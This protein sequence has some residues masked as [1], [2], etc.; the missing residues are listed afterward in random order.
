MQST[1]A[2]RFGNVMTIVGEVYDRPFTS[3]RLQAWF[4][5]LSDYAIED[6]ERSAEQHM[7]ASKFMP[8]PAELIGLIQPS[9]ADAAT[10]A[11]TEVPAL[12]RDSRNAKSANPVTE[13]TIQALGG[14]AALGQKTQGELVWIAKEFV[15]RYQIYV[16]HGLEVTALP[17]PHP[18]L[19]ETKQIGRVR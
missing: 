17:A 2:E 7:R 16:K 1:D 12:L 9:T 3:E 19:D 5:L 15:D 14:W 8:T 10:L 4:R 6:V 13:R 11:W 18:R